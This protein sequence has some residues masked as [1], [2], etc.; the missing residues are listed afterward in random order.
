MIY[1]WT[2]KKAEVTTNFY[3]FEIENRYKFLKVYKEC[4]YKCILGQD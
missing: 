2:T 3:E 1:N 4:N